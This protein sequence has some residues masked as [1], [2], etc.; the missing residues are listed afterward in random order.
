MKR[1]LFVLLQTFCYRISNPLFSYTVYGLTHMVLLLFKQYQ[2]YT[3][4]NNWW[5]AG[6]LPWIWQPPLI[7]GQE[8][9]DNAPEDKRFIIIAN[10]ACYLDITTI[11]ALFKKAPVTWVVKDSLLMK[12]VV[13]Q[14]IQLGIGTPIPRLNARASSEKI[15]R[16]TAYLRKEMNPHIAVFPEGTRTHDGEIGPFKRGFTLLMR[17]YEMDVL[18]ITICGFYT[19]APRNRFWTNPDAK[20]EVIV[21]PPVAYTTLKDLDDKTIAKKMR[22]IVVSSYHP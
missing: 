20:I 10:H 12:P 8:Y 15:L 18:P 3:R 16:R 17:E 14:V 1:K 11:T 2:L 22:D 13:G 7:K 19:F 9:I 5:A 4:V 21:H 6:V